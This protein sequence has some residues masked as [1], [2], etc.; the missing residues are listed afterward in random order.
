[1]PASSTLAVGPG[2]LPGRRPDHPHRG[3]VGEAELGDVQHRFAQVPA[4][5]RQEHP[6]LLGGPAVD[7]TSQ[8]EPAAGGA[9][10]TEQR[11]VV[12]VGR[13]RAAAGAPPGRSGSP[14][15]PQSR[16]GREQHSPVY[17]SREASTS[18]RKLVATPAALHVRATQ[19]PGDLAGA[20]HTGPALPRGL[21]DPGADEVQE[22]SA[23][24]KTP[25]GV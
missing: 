7:L 16:A 23:G 6:H 2:Q 20:A 25:P 15:V 4:G 17:G 13:R 14:A 21:L 10:D 11:P 24:S 1:M 18:T 22:R 9:V 12:G 8:L 19:K 5:R 3:D